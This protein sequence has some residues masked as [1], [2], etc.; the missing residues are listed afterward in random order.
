MSTERSDVDPATAP[1]AIVEPRRRLS[2][3]WL[4]PILAAVLAGGLIY[5]TLTLR[6]I[7]ITIQLSEGH[8]LAPGDSI[9]YRGIEVGTIRSIELRESLDSILL[10]ASLTEQGDQI[11][12]RGTRFWV[13]RPEITFAGI[14]G[15]ET[16][17]GPNYLAALPGDGRPQ[18]HFIGIE[19][20]P[21]VEDAA[22]GSLEILVSAPRQGSML[23]GAPVTF[24]GIDVG[25]I[26][27]V[28]LTSDGSSV[29]ARLHIEQPYAPL[30]R[31]NSRF[32]R[33]GGITADIGISG[34]E[35]DIDSLPTLLKGGVA[36]ATPPK[37][38]AGDPVLTGHRFPLAR[39]PRTEWLS[40]QPLVAIGHRLLPPGSSSPEVLRAKLAW[41]QGLIFR[42]TRSRQGWIVP[43][44]NGT[45]A[46]ADLLVPSDKAKE[47][48]VDLEIAGSMVALPDPSDLIWQHDGLALA[49]LALPEGAIGR[50]P[51]YRSRRPS[52]PEDL[53]VIGDPNAAPFPLAADRLREGDQGWLV[54]EAVSFDDDWHGAAVL[55]RTDGKLVGILLARDDAPRIVWIPEPPDRDSSNLPAPPVGN[56]DSE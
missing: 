56:D 42:G 24:R 20:P 35:V 46:P 3:A 52:A 25:V 47:D 55:A 40:W 37:D 1:T 31:Q 9:R 48:T 23:P 41:R 27:S 6:G 32:W 10:T 39:S 26:L 17:L 11:A 34:V 36:F 22:P 8:G 43:V 21:I 14:R 7:V 49:A 33:I 2:W 29:E 5:R 13:V 54:D 12:R 51:S 16:L 4:I 19:T 30:V 53:A 44:E 15:L 28:G 18:R 50:W 45:L 38:Q